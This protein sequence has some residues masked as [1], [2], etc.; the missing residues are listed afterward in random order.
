MADEEHLNIE[1]L[2]V[3]IVFVMPKYK[4]LSWNVCMITNKLKMHPKGVPTLK[5]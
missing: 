4:K 2:T 3:L 1:K 5:K